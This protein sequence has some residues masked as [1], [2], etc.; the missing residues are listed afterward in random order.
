MSKKHVF[1][2]IITPVSSKGKVCCRSVERFMST[3]TDVVDGFVPCLTTG[4][5]WRINNEAWE[6]M[7]KTCI[8]I[9]G[10][11]RVMVG[12]ERSSTVEVLELV[13]LA[14]TY[15]PQAIIVTTPFGKGVCQDMMVRHFETIAVNSDVDI[16]IYNESALSDNVMDFDSLLEVSKLNNVWGIKDSPN[17]TRPEE[18]ILDLRKAGMTYLIGWEE[19]LHEGKP[20][21]GNIVS[22][23]NMRPDLCTEDAFGSRNNFKK[24][25][26]QEA[27]DEFRL[28][29]YDWYRYIK[30]ILYQRG[31]ISSPSLVL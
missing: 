28:S 14:N 10:K 9:A 18:E 17:M 29:E 7:L 2:P 1:A 20:N 5:G 4:E 3:I 25:L 22:M 12:I 11:D 15:Q 6:I 21:D 31:S 30:D 27:I 24:K 13:E 26:V 16:V 8:D 23:A 19:D